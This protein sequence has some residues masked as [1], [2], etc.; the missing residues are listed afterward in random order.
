MTGNAALWFVDRHVE[1]GRADKI[2]FREAAG[3]RRSL[4]YGALA[5]G[6]A[7]L[8]GAFYRAGIQREE[9]AAMFVLDQI[10]FP[11][12]FWGAIKAGVVPI[13]LNTLLST[14]VYRTILQDSRASIAFVSKEMIPVVMP[15][16]ADC[17][18]V[19]QVVVIGAEAEG[20]T[21][22][23]AFVAGADPI[24]TVPCCADE[25]AFWLYS[26]GSTGQP[27]GVRH[28]HGALQVTCDTYGAQ[29]LGVTEG[30]TVF[31]A[32]KLFF[33]Y[34]LGNGMSF[35]MSVGA[36]AVLFDGRPTPDSVSDVLAAEK[37]TIYCGVPTLYAAMIHK[38]ESE[39]AHP[40]A[41]LRT[42]ISAGEALPAEIGRKWKDI[43][44]VDILDGVGSTEMLHIFLSNRAGD[45]QYGTS[46]VAVP[47]YDIRVV[48][49]D[50]AEVAPGGVGELLV[51]GGSA[52][53]DYWNQRDKSRA[54]F[55]GIWTRTGDKYEVGEGGRLI[56]CG[57][58]D[59]MFKVSGIWL[60]PFEVEQALAA[61]PAVL[62]AAVVARRDDDG[63]EKPMAFVVL[64]SGAGAD[65]LDGIK[66]H[67]KTAIGKWKYPRWIEVVDDLPKT[68]T[69]KIQRFKLREV[70]A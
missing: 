11:L 54:T 5:E 10:E 13:P 60:S 30:D 9:R 23:E 46:G 12:I 21:E 27:K 29:V 37:P 35:P 18:L 1:E 2:A 47:G 20:A 48:D 51:R 24:R 7:Q 31:S 55:E 64:K 39:G 41:P 8:A 42:C 45:V 32:A 57:R 49:E 25:V 44:G 22:I 53:A 19:R 40:D 52:A 67:V 15:A 3:Q 4:T 17:P 16:L 34:G 63:L 68:A 58:T 70:T 36:T 6:A 59:D 69:G 56:Y 38:W 26:S 61:H 14:D 50:G 33:A 28:V 43:W 66:E 62:E 65:A